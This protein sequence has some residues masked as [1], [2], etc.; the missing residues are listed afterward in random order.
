MEQKSMTALVST[1]SRAYY[2]ENNDVKIFND[3]VAKL[4]LSEQEYNQIEKSMAQ[5]IQFFNPAFCGNETEALRWIVDNQ[6]SPSPLGRAAFTERAL[7]NAVKFGTRQYLIFAAGYDSF[8]YRQ[9]EW[10]SRLQIFELDHPLMSMEKKQRINDIY[11]KK[12]LLI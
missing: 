10:A 3:S 4:L 1:F 9:P 11:G 8:A 6:L 5:G 7:E 12:S 2:S